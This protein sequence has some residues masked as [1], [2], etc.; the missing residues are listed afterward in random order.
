MLKSLAKLLAYKKA[1]GKTFALL[2]PGKALKWGAALF[3]LKKLV[4]SGGSKKQAS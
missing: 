3:L 2:H 4:G 1:P